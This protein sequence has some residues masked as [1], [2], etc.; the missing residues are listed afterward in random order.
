MSGGTV[1]QELIYLSR[2]TFNFSNLM[3]MIEVSDSRFGK[4]KC[5]Q[6]DST[7]N[8]NILHGVSENFSK[9]LGGTHNALCNKLSL[10]LNIEHMDN[11]MICMKFEKP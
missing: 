10:K 2:E 6:I 9:F 11:N 4:I 8:I 1:P 5:K 3:K 7:F